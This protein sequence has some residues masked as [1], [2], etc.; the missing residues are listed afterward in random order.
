MV[1]AKSKPRAAADGNLPKVLALRV[2]ASAR[3]SRDGEAGKGEREIAKGRC[4]NAQPNT[5]Y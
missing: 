1:G 5:H 2:L 3:D 4:A